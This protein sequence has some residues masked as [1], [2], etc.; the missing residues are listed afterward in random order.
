M[1]TKARGAAQQKFVALVEVKRACNR[2]AHGRR[3][4]QESFERRETGAAHRFGSCDELL[5]RS[6]SLHLRSFKTSSDPTSRSR[7]SS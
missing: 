1:R 4:G 7:A 3:L 6:T 2:A 5:L